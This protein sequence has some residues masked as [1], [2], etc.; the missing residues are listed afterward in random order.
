[1]F[2]TGEV[3]DFHAGSSIHWQLIKKYRKLKCHTS[4]LVTGSIKQTAINH[5]V[6]R[7]LIQGFSIQ[8]IQV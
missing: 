8:G 4:G 3:R 6:S 7:V 2:I 1:M 5:P